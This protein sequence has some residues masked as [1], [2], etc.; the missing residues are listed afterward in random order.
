MANRQD[1]NHKRKNALKIILCGIDDCTVVFRRTD[2]RATHIRTIHL[3]LYYNKCRVCRDVFSKSGWESHK[4]RCKPSSPQ[5]KQYKQY[6]RNPEWKSQSTKA[7]IK[8]KRPSKPKRTKSNQK[9]IKSSLKSQN[10]KYKSRKGTKPVKIQSPN[11]ANTSFAS[12]PAPI[13][14]SKV[15]SKVTKNTPK[16]F[17]YIAFFHT[18]HQFMQYAQHIA[19]SVSLQKVK[20]QNHHRHSL[21]QKRSQ[22]HRSCFFQPSMP[23]LKSKQVKGF[24]ILYFSVRFINT[25]TT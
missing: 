14:F 11:D 2:T 12:L 15:P 10:K 20:W 25:H 18:V 19:L 17:Y 9:H 22:M 1:P 7:F 21:C 23:H 24:I 4:K 16:R 5:S 13:S 8:Y 6:Q 3:G